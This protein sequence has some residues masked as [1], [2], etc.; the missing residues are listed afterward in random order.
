MKDKMT[1][2]FGEDNL[3]LNMKETINFNVGGVKL[4]LDSK[5]GVLQLLDNGDRVLSEVDF[6]TEKI[7]T[8]A[9]YDYDN[10]ELV[11]EYENAQAVR[12]PI[13]TDFSN[14]YTIEQVNNL[15]N[16]L[17]LKLNDIIQSNINSLDKKITDL[18]KNK[19]NRNELF[20][21]SYN[22]LSDKPTIPRKIS[23]LINDREFVTNTT[24]NL[25][26][27]YSKIEVYTKNEVLSLIDKIS[28]MS[29]LVV[30]TLPTENISST[31]IYLVPTIT[32]E[33]QNVYKEYIYV[34]NTWELIGNT[35]VDLT[36][37]VREEQV[38]DIVE[39]NAEE[40]ETLKIA[41]SE[42]YNS[43]SEEEIPTTKAVDKIISNKNFAKKDELFSKNY[44]DLTNK[45][46]IP[47]KLSD[48]E[49]DIT[50]VDEEKVMEIVEEKLSLKEDK[51]NLGN[52]AYKDSLNKTDIGLGNVLNVES[53][54]K[55]ETYSKTE[56]DNINSKKV[57][58][59]QGKGL[60]TNDLTNELLSKLNSLSNYDDT[61]IQSQIDG[62]KQVLTSNDVDYDTLQE[63]VDALKNNISSIG[64]IF[65]QL[66]KKVDKIDGKQLSTNDYTTS[67]KNKLANLNNYDDTEIKQDIVDLENNK[68]NKNELFSKNYNDLSNKPTIPSKVSDLTNDTGYITETYVDTAISN[69]ITKV[70]NEEV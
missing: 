12:V 54:S 32:S 28:T 4:K 22:D 61:N 29:M 36:G 18:E 52:L 1:I 23:D 63:L 47:T 31:T 48:L 16:S 46:T 26:N 58:K 57:D 17:K 50:F 34:N 25:V 13:K 30:D 60:S 43:S 39:E 35:K 66:S 41:T 24:N 49:Q 51:T 38:M 37:L 40:V 44:N 69:A 3:L 59:I 19:A 64:D 67:E 27:Y 65:S 20:S 6:P 68:A 15:L 5:S 55:Q 56:I 2:S 53:Y 70:L 9:Y 8:N 42:N 62:I 14:H 7:I 10:Q 45:P 33:N 11:L 21:G